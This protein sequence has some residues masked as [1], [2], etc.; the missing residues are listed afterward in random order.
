MLIQPFPSGP[1]DTNAY[2]VV[3]QKSSVA[4]VIDASSGSCQEISSYLTQHPYKIEK[5]LLTHSHWDHIADASL[6]KK[7]Y[8]TP[9]YIHVED[10]KNLEHPGSDRL[11]CWVEVQGVSPDHLL[12]DGEKIKLGELVFQ[13]IHTP[14][15]SPGGV[16]Y[17]CAEEGVLFSGDTLFKGSIGILSLPTSE[18]ER[19]WT[20]LHRLSLLPGKTKIYPGHGPSTTLE[21][22]KWLSQAREIFE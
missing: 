19:M 17:Y 4:A 8:H 13:V 2:L 7:K 3:C 6:F 15:H 9:I 14:G 18:P 12:S 11:R 1:L 20:S 16:C 21:E 10:A 22:E 5:L